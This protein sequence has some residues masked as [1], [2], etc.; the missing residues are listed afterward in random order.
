MQSQRFQEQISQKLLS[1]KNQSII[2]SFRDNFMK[3]ATEERQ[4]DDINFD[5]VAY[6]LFA[7]L[8][9]AIISGNQEIIQIQKGITLIEKLSENQQLTET[10]STAL[11]LSKQFITIT[12]QMDDCNEEL[13]GVV[14]KK[15]NDLNSPMQ[16]F[17]VFR[18]LVNK[19]DVTTTSKQHTC[20]E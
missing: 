3:V 7:G 17:I 4:F 8:I 11:Q 12:P 2:A 14:Q 20:K 1:N 15:I 6:S 9:Y 10:T 18:Q 13:L 16:A 19:F 5:M